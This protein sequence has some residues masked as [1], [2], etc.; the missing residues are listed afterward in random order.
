MCASYQSSPFHRY[1]SLVCSLTLRCKRRWCWL[2]WHAARHICWA[3][4]AD[5]CDGVGEL[6]LFVY[7]SPVT[8]NPFPTNSPTLVCLLTL[9]CEQ[10]RCWFFWRARRGTFAVAGWADMREG[11]GELLFRTN[12]FFLFSPFFLFMRYL[13]CFFCLLTVRCEG[14]WCCSSFFLHASQRCCWAD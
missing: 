7:C 13:L 8:S 12:L 1:L 3:G 5:V 14:R 4:W 10:R 9:R 11:V 2:F 6:E